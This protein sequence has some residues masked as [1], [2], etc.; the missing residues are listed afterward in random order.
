MLGLVFC[1]R[2]AC[3]VV[4]L[5]RKRCCLPFCCDSLDFSWLLIG[6]I[7]QSAGSNGGMDKGA[8][9]DQRRNERPGCLLRGGFWSGNEGGR[10]SVE[11]GRDVSIPG[12]ALPITAH[13]GKADR[14]QG[15]EK[16]YTEKMI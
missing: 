10:R 3:G 8:E 13:F 15:K 16:Q 2:V 11:G 7:A 6:S 1:S 12:C 4:Y 9:C 14:S 5:Q